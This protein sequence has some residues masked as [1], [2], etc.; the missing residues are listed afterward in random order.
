MLV[1]YGESLFGRRLLEQTEFLAAPDRFHSGSIVLRAQGDLQVCAR[2]SQARIAL[3]CLAPQRDGLI[4]QTAGT[5]QASQ[6]DQGDH[7][8]RVLPPQGCLV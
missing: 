7:G 3:Q 6:V 2:L 1:G 4:Q 5:V 8:V